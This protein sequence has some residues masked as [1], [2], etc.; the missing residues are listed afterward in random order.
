MILI[1]Y[2]NKDVK[3]FTNL[4]KAVLTNGFIKK[5]Q[6]AAKS[7][8]ELAKKYRQDYLERESGGEINE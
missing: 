3:K 8:I 7:E 6:K 1:H 2:R 5:S 4:Q